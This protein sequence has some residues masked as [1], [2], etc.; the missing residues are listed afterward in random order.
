MQFIRRSLT[1]VIAN[2]DSSEA[3]GQ[4]FDIRSMV[5]HLDNALD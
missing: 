1:F 3:L 4:I 5:E 2:R